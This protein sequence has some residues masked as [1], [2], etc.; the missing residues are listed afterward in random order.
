MRFKPAV[1]THIVE[2]PIVDLMETHIGFAHIRRSL[3]P[4]I[5]N[6]SVEPHIRTGPCI[7]IFLTGPL[8]PISLIAS[9]MP[10]LWPIHGSLYSSQSMDAF[11]QIGP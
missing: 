3:H 9:W 4:Y 1:K 11:I 7:P 5:S 10:I 8:V 6:Q 2:K